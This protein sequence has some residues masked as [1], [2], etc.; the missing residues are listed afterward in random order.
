[1]KTNNTNGISDDL[2]EA[3]EQWIDK[4]GRVPGTID[5]LDRRAE[6]TERFGSPDRMGDDG[7]CWHLD[8]DDAAVFLTS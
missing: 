7:L 4:N 8:E 6:M 3:I 5:I 2:R 1:M